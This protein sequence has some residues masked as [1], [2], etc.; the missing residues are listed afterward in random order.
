M[1]FN[2]RVIPGVT[3]NFQF[4]ESL[5]RYE[6]AKRCFGKNAKVIDI[7]C[8]T[9][10]GSAV[11]GEKYEV[12]AIDNNNEAIEYANKHYSKKA[13]FLKANATTLPFE[14]S[15][16]DAAC[17]FEVIEHLKDTH[18]FMKEVHRVLRPGGKF[19]LSTP[20][21]FFHSTGDKLKSPYH[22]K[23]YTAEEL[24]HLLNKYFKTVGIKSQTKSK[25][26][27]T[28]LKDFMAS[29]KARE[30][31]VVSD[32]LRIRKIIPQAFKEKVWKCLGGLFGRKSQENLETRDFPIKPGNLSKAEY[33]V[34]VCKK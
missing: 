4:K 16:F 32:I 34:A 14:D 17:S 3:A 18:K 8:G 31:F 27:K 25:R 23:E 10:Y 7:G 22:I 21:K 26:A 1:D 30:R 29:Q 6:F 12:T 9:G 2:E 13:R 5:A 11:L 19:I 28:A 20:N 33:F 24:G 15:K